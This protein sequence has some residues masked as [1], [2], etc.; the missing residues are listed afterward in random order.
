[1]ESSEYGKERYSQGIRINA[2][3]ELDKE[4]PVL[5]R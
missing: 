3:E 1:M 5:V 2:K 4:R